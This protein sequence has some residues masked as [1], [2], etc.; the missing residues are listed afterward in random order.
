MTDQRDHLDSIGEPPSEDRGVTSLRPRDGGPTETIA[1]PARA[2]FGTLAAGAGVL[3][4][5]AAARTLR[6]DHVHG[7]L[8]AAA[9][10]CELLFALAMG[11]RPTRGPLQ[12]GAALNFVVM[13]VGLAGFGASGFADGA[14]T[15]FGAVTV[16]ALAA[17]IVI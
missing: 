6:T 13:I 16:V 11:V 17:A 3:L 1:S 8:F 7:A 10:W 12:A 9:G 15:R 4:L 5:V 2:L 14:I